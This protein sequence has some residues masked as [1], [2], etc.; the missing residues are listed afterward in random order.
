MNNDAE[1]NEDLKDALKSYG[2]KGEISRLHKEMMPGMPRIKSTPVPV[3][4]IGRFVSRAVAAILIFCVG[5]VAIIYF[6]TSPQALFD[7]NYVPYENSVQR[8][9][10]RDL[11]SAA[12]KNFITGQEYLDNNQPGEAIQSFE[13]VLAIDSATNQKILKDDAEFYLGMAYLK[14]NRPSQAY[15]ILNKIH[16]DRNHLYNDQVSK[17]FLVK[18][19]IVSWKDKK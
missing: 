18:L 14:Q 8:S 9:A 13:K 10:D 16:S 12:T 17:W 15:T 2:L 5:T 11:Q 6:T 19:K 4:N 1:N 7:K 3:F